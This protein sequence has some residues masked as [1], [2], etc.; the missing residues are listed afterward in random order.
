M[1]P[2]LPDPRTAD[3]VVDAY[4]EGI[5]MSLVGE[6]LKLSHAKRVEKAETFIRSL[7]SIRGIANQRPNETNPE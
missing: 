4:R 5:D 6:N 2:N 3:P 7:D 1:L